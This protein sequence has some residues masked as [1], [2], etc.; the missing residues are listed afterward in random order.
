[1]QVRRRVHLGVNGS[2]SQGGQMVASI[3]QRKEVVFQGEPMDEK[4][5]SIRSQEERMMDSSI[6]VSKVILLENV[7]YQGGALKGIWPPP[8]ERKSRRRLTLVKKSGILKLGFQIDKDELEED[9][10]APAFAETTE[11]ILN[12]NEDWIIDLGCSNHMTND[13]KK[14][15]D[16]TDY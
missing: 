12:Y 8:H 16:M 9:M 2:Q 3:T 15:E 13:D 11:P 14:F 10:E 1:M 7:D 6:V 5:S 4:T